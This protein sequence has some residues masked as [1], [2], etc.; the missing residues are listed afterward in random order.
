MGICSISETL[1]VIP[2]TISFI[3]CTL[4]TGVCVFCPS[5]FIKSLNVSHSL[6]SS[7][8][9]DGC[10]TMRGGRFSCG[11]VKTCCCGSSFD[12]AV[13]LTDPSI[14]SWSFSDLLECSNVSLLDLDLDLSVPELPLRLILGLGSLMG[15]K[16]NLSKGI[17]ANLLSL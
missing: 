6:S 3:A 8:L 5:I 17:L 4:L 12:W 7:V 15:A 10:C 11:E 13:S 14:L 16:C 2:V 9:T 1:L